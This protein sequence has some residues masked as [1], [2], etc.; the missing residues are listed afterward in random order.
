VPRGPITEFTCRVAANPENKAEAATRILLI[1]IACVVG[2]N[3]PNAMPVFG[4]ELLYG[5]IAP[6]LA[7]PVPPDLVPAELPKRIVDTGVPTL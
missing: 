5:G 7:V 3:G 1:V 2:A 6:M 4:D